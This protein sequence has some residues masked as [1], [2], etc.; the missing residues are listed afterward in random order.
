MKNCSRCVFC[1]VSA[2]FTTS[3]FL[4]YLYELIWLFTSLKGEQIH[5][6]ENTTKVSHCIAAL[7]I[8]HLC[9]IDKSS[10]PF[11]IDRGLLDV[12]LSLLH[13]LTYHMQ[14]ATNQNV[15]T[16]SRQNS[17]KVTVDKEQQK[18][19][20]E[21]AINQEE[22]EKEE[23]QMEDDLFTSSGY[24][25]GNFHMDTVTASN[26]SIF[27]E[28]DE[29]EGIT[30]TVTFDVE[31]SNQTLDASRR[32][33]S[34]RAR[35]DSYIVRADTRN[36]NRN[37]SPFLDNPASTFESREEQ[38]LSPHPTTR[39]SSKGESKGDTASDHQQLRRISRS[40]SVSLQL[41]KINKKDDE[42]TLPDSEVLKNIAKH[43]IMIT[44]H[45]LQHSD[46][47]TCA[48]VLSSLY[49][50]VLYMILSMFDDKFK[51]EI[52]LPVSCALGKCQR[53]LMESIQG[54]SLDYLRDSMS[55]LRKVFCQ[56][57]MPDL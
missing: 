7:K 52:G 42:S 47:Q 26:D 40:M 17:M 15:F 33:T 2:I 25:R 18:Q 55:N 13:S 3:G 20:T 31:D 36:I 23:D 37:Q 11:L 27:Y 5:R 14:T 6:A 49:I 57:C 34:G 10:S 56:F 46:E 1:F 22:E 51:A 4:E 16:F 12:L 50:P 8:I 28:T 19:T 45:I 48:N 53:F 29:H 43:A 24:F 41:S 44:Y 21:L 38:I 39:E 9:S 54:R 30:R 35:A 32:R